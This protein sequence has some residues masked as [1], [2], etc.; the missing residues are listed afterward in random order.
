[1]QFV[2]WALVV[3][4]VLLPAFTAWTLW[5]A[6]GESASSVLLRA[7]VAI[8]GLGF[9]L[10]ACNWSLLSVWAM[11]AL[12]LAALACLV[13]PLRRAFALPAFVP[14]SGRQWLGEAS[15][16]VLLVL[17]VAAIV[18]GLRG[19]YPEPAVDLVFPLTEPW[20]VSHG[21][22]SLLLNPHATVRA[23]RY[24]I[25]VLGLNR[26]GARARGL[27]PR[28]PE[29]YAA[30]GDPVLAP[31]DGEVLTAVDGLRDLAPPRRD[32]DRPAGNHLAIACGD[33][34]VVLAHLQRG[35]VIPAAGERVEAGQRIGR[36]G[37]SGNTSEPHLHLHAVH[38]RVTDP[39][40]LLYGGDPAPMRF[41]GRFLVRHDS[42]LWSDVP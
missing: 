27:L 6:R 37:N 38:G 29:R 7:A 16:L 4:I 19:R 31:C 13:R 15:W 1:M 33:F 12:G 32:P 24:A 8:A 25:D 14:L 21:G 9:F 41:G 26:L 35:S 18:P 34:T 5:R 2:V 28:A 40:Q 30:F 17:F 36:I 10:L 42:S 23:Q 3:A 22:T 11:P 39:E 20:Y